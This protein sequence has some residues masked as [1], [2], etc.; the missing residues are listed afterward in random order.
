[1]ADVDKDK[2]QVMLFYLITGIQKWQDNFGVIPDELYTGMLRFIQLS[3]E[4]NPNPPVDLYQFV[5]I[6]HKP[7][8]EWGIP[9]LEN[10]YPEH[11]PLLEEEIGLVADTDEF[12][13]RYISPQDAEQQNMYDILKYCRED[14]RQLRDEYTAIRTFLSEKQ[15]AVISARELN[16]FVENFQDSELIKLIRHCYQEITQELTNFRICPHCGWT[17]EYKH[18]RWRCNKENICHSLADMEIL[19]SFEFGNQ[20]VFRLNPGIQRFVL[21]PGISELRLAERLRKKGYEVEMYPNVD[22]FDLCV[23]QAG[24]DFFL[25]VKDFKDP[26]T[27]ASFFNEQDA[28]YLEKYKEHCVIVV[29]QYRN[30]L[31]REYRKRAQMYLNETARHCIQIVME[32]EV[33][34][35]L[36]EVFM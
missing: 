7:S 16:D 20:R 21:L 31:F 4:G 22:Q 26:R 24:R 5:Q 18:D 35:T 11:A 29:P 36:Q 1:M 9:N 19:A 34:Q 17:M 25:D 30:L 14:G 10:D 3:A 13:N 33:E 6:L 32:N 27:L 12:M 28:S 23:K 2:R 15:H 8:R